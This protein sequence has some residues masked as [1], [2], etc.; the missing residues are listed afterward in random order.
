MTYQERLPNRSEPSAQTKQD[1]PKRKEP[2]E[3]VSQAEATVRPA[4]PVAPGRRPLFRA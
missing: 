1:E 3:Q 4:S 2:Q